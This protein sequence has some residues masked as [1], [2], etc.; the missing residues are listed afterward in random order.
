[1]NLA[2]IMNV[3]LDERIKATFSSDSMDGERD[4]IGDILNS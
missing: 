4:E 1:M 2:N 3:K